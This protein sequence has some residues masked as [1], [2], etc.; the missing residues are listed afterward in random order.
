[1]ILLILTLSCQ[2]RKIIYRAFNQRQQLR[3]K[4]PNRLQAPVAGMHRK[5]PMEMLEMLKTQ[6]TAPIK[7]MIKPK[8]PDLPTIMWV[9]KM[10]KYAILLNVFAGKIKG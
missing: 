10:K 4:T 1:M 3:A 7:L 8:T 2:L 9:S 5:L 6:G